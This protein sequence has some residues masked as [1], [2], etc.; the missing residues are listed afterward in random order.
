MLR[1]LEALTSAGALPHTITSEANRL[2]W[3]DRGGHRKEY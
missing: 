2:R 1:A 3:V